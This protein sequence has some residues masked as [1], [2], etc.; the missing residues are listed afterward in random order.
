[1]MALFLSSFIIAYL[2]YQQSGNLATINAQYSL[3]DDRFEDLERSS[4][5]LTKFAR[6]YAVTDDEKYRDAFNQ[7]LATRLGATTDFTNKNSGFLK[8]LPIT[9]DELEAIQESEIAFQ[10][11]V[12]MEKRAIGIIEKAAKGEINNK[13]QAINLL[14]SLE[15]ADTK[16][17]IMFPIAELRESTRNRLDTKIGGLRSHINNMLVVFYVVSSLFFA[18]LLLMIHFSRTRIL[19]P[20]Y[21]LSDAIKTGFDSIP[22]NVFHEDEVGR[23][24]EKFFEMKENME[25]SYQELKELSFRDHLTGIFNRNYFYQAAEIEHKKQRR[26]ENRLCLL[27]LDIDHFK[28]VNDTYG[29]LIGDDILRKI[30]NNISEVIRDTDI[31]ARYGGEEFIVL[32]VNSSIA[33]AKQIAE[34][35]RLKVSE[36][37]FQIKDGEFVMEVNTTISIGVSLVRKEDANIASAISLADKALYEAK[38]K[39]R[40]QVKVNL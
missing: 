29:H 13:E 17:K 28:A 39:G 14:S 7:V 31:L 12:A 22:K 24:A 4:E 25:R 37:I 18:V 21:A 35:I 27:M 38:N 9:E 32:L 5:D 1:M 15:H 20:V 6:L 2:L 16:K 23:L 3:L 33:D 36:D 40:N 11:V 19:Q 30:S 26:E 8:D 34:K 10:Q